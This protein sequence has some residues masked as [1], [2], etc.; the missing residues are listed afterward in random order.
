MLKNVMKIIVEALAEEY[1]KEYVDVDEKNNEIYVRDDDSNNG[2][3]ITLEYM[4]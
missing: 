2:V 4:T 3:K 1:L